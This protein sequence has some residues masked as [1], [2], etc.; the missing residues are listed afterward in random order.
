MQMRSRT[1]WKIKLRPEQQPRVES[2][3][4]GRMLIPTPMLV[5]EEVKKI[6]RGKL[7]TPE[8]I[9]HRLAE[10]FGADFT[11]PMTTGI[12]LNIVA[13][14]SDEI[15]GEGGRTLAPWWR[16]VEP[17]GTLNPK[18]PPGSDRHA[19][20][21]RGEG[22]VLRRKKPTVWQVVDAAVPS[23][24]SSRRPKARA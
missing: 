21:L 24:A 19:A 6:R 15:E 20:L 11:C 17:D 3:A 2:D 7:A 18:R 1:P 13:A 23:A 5:A 10:R 9:R 16:I 22:H 4:R 12:F 14:A 8:M